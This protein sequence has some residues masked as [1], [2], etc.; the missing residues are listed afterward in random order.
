[1][2]LEK[3]EALLFQWKYDRTL[4]YFGEKQLNAQIKNAKKKLIALG[5]GEQAM[6]GSISVHYRR[7]AWQEVAE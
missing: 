3:Y 6:A 1:M 5:L 2:T 7:F 4:A